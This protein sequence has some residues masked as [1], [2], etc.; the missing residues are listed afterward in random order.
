MHD[1]VIYVKDLLVG[2]VLL[3]GEHLRNF[4]AVGLGQGHVG[5]VELLDVL[6]KLQQDM[7]VLLVP[8]VALEFED[9]LHLGLFQYLVECLGDTKLY[10]IFLT[11]R[12]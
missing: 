10:S 7:L 11:L 4:F 6:D 9:S 3:V 8:D 2:A 1:P 12:Q 5:P